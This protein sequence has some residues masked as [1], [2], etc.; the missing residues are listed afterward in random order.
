YKSVE[1]FNKKMKQTGVRCEL[2]GYDGAAHG[3][4]N[5]GR[6][7]NKAYV[8]TVTRADRFLASLGYVEGPP[9]VNE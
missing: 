5:H 3:F 8:D 1:A 9:T 7:G 6:G 2:V 4:F